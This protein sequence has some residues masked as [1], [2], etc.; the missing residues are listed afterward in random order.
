M[1]TPTTGAGGNYSQP[2]PRGCPG[3]HARV[4]NVGGYGVCPWCNT[5][6]KVRKDGTLKAHTR[7]AS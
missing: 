1:R 7:P 5:D 2:N 4:N 3:S 6:R